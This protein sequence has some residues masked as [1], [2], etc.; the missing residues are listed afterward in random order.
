MM[1]GVSKNTRGRFQS[2]YK[3]RYVGI[4]DT[5]E[6]AAI[7]YDDAVIADVGPRGI[8]FPE[9]FIGDRTSIP[10]TQSKFAL[11]DEDMFDELSKYLWNCN[12]GYASRDRGKADGPGPQCIKMHQVIGGYRWDHISRDT[13]DNRKCNLRP[14]TKQQQAI[15]R[16]LPSNNSSGFKGVHYRN[17]KWKVSIGTSYNRKHLGSFYDPVEA[18]LAYDKAARKYFGEFATLNFPESGEQG[19]QL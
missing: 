19:C 2:Q 17:K 5:E 18:A 1:R 8:N 11:I 6:Q 10:L 9:R 13:L 7:A 15:N 12:N 14:A 3:H 16:G 4:F